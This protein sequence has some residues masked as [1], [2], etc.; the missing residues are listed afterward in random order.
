MP[1]IA[2]EART[3]RRDQII[4]AA[5]E[6]FAR[7]G[8]HA[9]TMADIA[10]TAGVSKGTPYLYFPGKEALFIALYEEWDCGLAARVDAAVGGL[11]EPAR[12]S[13]RTVLAAVASAIAAHVTGNPQT[14]RVLMEATTLAAYEPAI[15]AKVQA[16]NAASLD[17]LTGLFQAGI[18]AGQWPAG[19]D[20]ALRAR[21]FMAGLYGLMSQWHLAPGTFPLQAAMGA[22]AGTDA[23][24]PGEHRGDTEKKGDGT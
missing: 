5:A 16:A 15:A 17:Q 9:T 13:P 24:G 8:Y 12:R 14:C 18:A 22:L 2:D 19:A 1:K 10:E 20:P 21:L 3:A 11:A 23:V 4:A 7:A 6:C